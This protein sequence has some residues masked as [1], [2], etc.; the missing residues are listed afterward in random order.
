MFLLI[1]IMIFEIKKKFIFG[2]VVMSDD[3]ERLESED[4]FFFKF[5]IVKNDKYEVK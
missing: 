2:I 3:F 5:L 1:G 4:L